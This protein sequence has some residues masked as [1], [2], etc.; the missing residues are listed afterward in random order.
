MKN[1]N[2]FSYFFYAFI[3]FSFLRKGE[4]IEAI[5]WCC[6][7]NYKSSWVILALQRLGLYKSAL[8]IEIN[9]F[10]TQQWMARIIS[11]AA[12]GK[13]DDAND[14]LLK[15]CRKF[16]LAY[17]YV[18]L[19]KSLAPYMP[20]EA[21]NILRSTEKRT[22]VTLH[23]ALLLRNGQLKEAQTYLM[24][25]EQHE[26]AKQPEL[27]LYASMAQPDA[28]PAQQLQRLNAFLHSC[29][30]PPLA[31]QDPAMPPGPCNVVV[32]EPV[33]VPPVQGPL[34]SVLVTTYRTG[35]RAVR[36]IESIL[37]QSYR[38]LEVVVVDDASG[39]NTP[40]LL[41]QLAQ[42]D[43]RVRVLA[44]PANVGTYVAKSIGLQAARGEF[45]T[46][47]DSDD[48]SHPCKIA[49][50]V[51]P[52]LDEP[53]LVASISYLLRMQDDGQFYAWSVHPL[54]R[55]NQS[56]L[57]FRR[58]LVLAKAGA[59]DCVRTGADSEFYARLRL[60]FG[61]KAVK[62]IRQPLSLVAHRPG[63]LMTDKKTGYSDKG[64]SVE[65]LDYVESWGRWHIECLA[66]GK[67]PYLGLLATERAFAAPQG[68]E[69]PAA[70]IQQVQLAQQVC[71]IQNNRLGEA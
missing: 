58:E 61:K 67:T 34:V 7:L 22:P 54:M 45:V 36:A 64:I 40:Q 38:N 70:H 52:L 35:Q 37:Q 65:R 42:Q 48:W 39:D 21:L 2:L 8:L 71:A 10:S 16:S 29:N 18:Q 30:V 13:H 44:L 55:I 66:C 1:R 49:R 28:V 19:A 17:S 27:H 20:E 53:E 59:W 43:A 5:V 62:R 12:C 50:Q 69:V 31:L 46:C 24:Q 47:H 68:I 57:L 15:R 6:K 51:Q 41:A 25:L 63:S 56:S 23:L 26:Y 9:S 4:Y 14:E 33:P 3:F 11:L 60:V 32:A